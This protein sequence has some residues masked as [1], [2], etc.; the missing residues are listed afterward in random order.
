MLSGVFV[1][2]CQEQKMPLERILYMK[3]K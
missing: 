1:I 3:S 2:F